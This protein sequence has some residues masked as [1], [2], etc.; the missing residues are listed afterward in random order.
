MRVTKYI[1]LL[2]ITGLCFGCQK[3]GAKV[4]KIQMIS[5]EEM[6]SLLDIENVQ[7]IDV[8]IPCMSIAPKVAEVPSARH[9]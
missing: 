8:R 3:E 1:Y 5:V 6:D 2:M 9:F 4:S 7:L